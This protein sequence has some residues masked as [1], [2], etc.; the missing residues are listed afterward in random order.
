MNE[1]DKQRAEA[2]RGPFIV[3]EDYGCEG[4]HPKSYDT[5]LEAVNAHSYQ[6]TTIVTKTVKY[7]VTE[8]GP[9]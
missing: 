8:I 4:W 3:W 7:E 1:A 9:L 2:I 6:S 5:L